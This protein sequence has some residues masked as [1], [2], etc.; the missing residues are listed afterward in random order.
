MP[1]IAREYHKV[2]FTRFECDCF[3]IVQGMQLIMAPAKNDVTRMR[4]L[5]LIEI[6]RELNIVNTR[7]PAFRVYM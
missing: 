2:T 1:E 6:I 7:Q 4:V 5:L 3:R